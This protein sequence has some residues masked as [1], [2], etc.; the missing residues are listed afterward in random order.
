MDLDGT[1]LNS[2]KNVS[3]YTV[4]ILERAKKAKAKIV[5]A[6]ARSKISSQRIAALIRP[7]YMILNGGALILD[8]QNK[9]LYENFISAEAAEKLIGIAAKDSNFG[10]ITVETRSGYYVN[11]REPAWHPDYLH[12]TYCDF[13]EPFR[14]PAYKVTVEIHDEKTAEAIAKEFPLLKMM[15]FFEQNWYGIY[16]QGTGKLNALEKIAEIEKIPLDRVTSFGDDIND[17]EMIK[18]CGTGIAMSNAAQEVKNAAK[19]ICESN[20][21]DGVAKWI[22]KN[23]L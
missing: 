22:E 23:I 15:R 18:H 20:N 19:F 9:I 17:L 7:D 4:S 3:D 5:I 14:E 6:T 8:D 2:K 1:L 12:G 13:S 10:F 21:D 16:A 11:Y